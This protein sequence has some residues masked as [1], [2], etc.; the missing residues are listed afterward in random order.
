VYC[1][2]AQSFTDDLTRPPVVELP[3]ARGRA[4]SAAKIPFTLSKISTVTATV[5]RKGAVVWSHTARIGYGRRALSLRPA[6]AG[7]LQVRLRAVDL[8]GNVG[9]T[10]GTLHV[11]RAA[12]KGAAER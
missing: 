4:G 8:A 7:P 5:L 12:R 10:T 6:K 11:A 2:K 9:T 1:D 3:D